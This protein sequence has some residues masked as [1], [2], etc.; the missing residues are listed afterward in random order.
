MAVQSHKGR[1]YF[2]EHICFLQYFYLAEAEELM[3]GDLWCRCQQ[4]PLA[5][6]TGQIL[7]WHWV[8]GSLGDKRA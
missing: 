1:H 6:E 8:Q 7:L 2:W 4:S 3:S 5:R